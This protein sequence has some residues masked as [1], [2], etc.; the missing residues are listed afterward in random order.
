LEATAKNSG[1]RIFLIDEPGSNL[2]A[3][4]Q[5]DILS[6]FEKQKD[7][8]QIIFT[9][10]S[11]YLLDVD[12]VYRVHA[13]ERSDTEDDKSE[14]KVI[15]FHKLGS[16]S[17]DTLL[18]LYTS[19]GVDASHQAVIS[20]NNNVLLEEISAYFYLKGFW[21]LFNKIEVVHFLPA[22]G[23]PNLP[24]L[25]NLMLGWGLSFSVV[26]DDEPHGRKVLKELKDS[27]VC[28]DENLIKIDSCS[29]IEDL[30]TKADFTGLVL[31]NSKAKIGA[32]LNSEYVKVEKISK[33]IIARDFMISVDDE[34]LKLSDLS[35]GTKDKVEVLLSKIISTLEV[36]PVVVATPLEIK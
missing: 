26:L 17:V 16:A 10:H 13:V 20:R 31:K 34:S 19:M 11:P 32:K 27:R 30:F 25:A 9:T 24:L 5:K 6:I 29:G 33:V 7:N 35:Q 12:K 3:K 23:C 8:L 15:P 4:A 2:H 1:S 28:K 21:K 36:V 14:T 18:P 22:T